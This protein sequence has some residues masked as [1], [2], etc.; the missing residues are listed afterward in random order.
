MPEDF[1]KDNFVNIA[2]SIALIEGRFAVI[3]RAED[4]VLAQNGILKLDA[5]SM[6]LQIIGE[7]I[8]KIN[9]SDPTFLERYPKIE[10]DMNMRLNDIISHHY[11]TIDHEIIYDICHRYI[12]L[13]KKTIKQIIED[14]A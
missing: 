2:E 8:K 12:P 9:K 10:W 4:F 13:F 6:R 5:I 11:D 14:F 1:I 7:L 3:K